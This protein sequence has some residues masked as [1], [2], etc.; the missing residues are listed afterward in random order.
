MQ[1]ATAVRHQ[2]R[3]TLEP[4]MPEEW[5]ELIRRLGAGFFH[6]PLG[7]RAG[8]PEGDPIFGRFYR[9]GEVMGIVA[10]V[11]TP[12][13]LGGHFRHYYFPSWPV[14]AEP[15][16]RESAMNRLIAAFRADG[17]A[18]ARWDSFDA[19]VGGPTPKVPQ[20]W[21]YL[22]D[23][24]Q[25][26]EQLHWPESA[27]HRRAIR[28]GEKG[29]WQLRELTGAA[30]KQVLGQVLA[31]AIDRHA[32]RGVH[33]GGAVPPAVTDVAAPGAPWDVRT[34]A[35]FEGETLLAAILLGRCSRRAY[36]LVGGA[37]E[38]GYAQGAS[39]WLQAQVAN[40][41]FDEGI[42][43]YNLGGAS[44]HAPEPGDPDHGLHRFKA[45]FGAKVVPCAGDRWIL[46]AGHLRGHQ[47]FGWAAGL[48]P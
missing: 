19:A 22:L 40:R 39:V 5:P 29:G 42:T 44:R 17:V 6:S 45:G 36:Y 4:R 38:A 12:C 37:T 2:E 11:R 14:F 25:M 41:L 46:L 7:L 13:R 47:L 16:H 27:G 8:A 23:L 3:W 20:R 34:Y 30:A 35:A 18:E 21:E 26:D 32:R 24:A 10:G 15:A 1:T 31:T 33:H 43:H 48:V 28:R 9:D